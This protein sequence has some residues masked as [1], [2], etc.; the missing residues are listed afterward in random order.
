MTMNIYPLKLIL[1]FLILL[2]L[3]H[4]SF[5]RDSNPG[6]IPDWESAGWSYD[7]ETGP[8][9]WSTLS[10]AYATC[11]AGSLQSPVDISEA[12]YAHLPALKFSY[13][14]S[15]TSIHRKPKQL[16]LNYD[17][18][19]TLKV[20]DKWYRFL[21]FDFHTPGEHSFRGRTAD[22]E[23]HLHHLSSAGEPL[24]VAIPVNGGHRKN[25]T[26]ARIWDNV[27]E[28][29]SQRRNRRVGINAMFLLPVDRSYYLYQGSET[30]PPCTEDVKWI[31]FK[32]PIR[33]SWDE[34]N[35]YKSIIGPNARKIQPVNNRAIL[36]STR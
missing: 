6:T 36:T 29:K 7:G 24:I 26:L 25:F 31:V 17:S 33:V 20:G 23:I 14:T 18:G 2:L 10:D 19:S 8:T 15:M 16:W 1:N 9:N 34:I 5:A 22:M 12:S 32:T 21:G 3:S 27:P 28:V 4:P 35:H 13:R 11:G 30:R